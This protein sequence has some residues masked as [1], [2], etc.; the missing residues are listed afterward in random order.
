M[1]ALALSLS[2]RNVREDGGGALN[3][4]Q[5]EQRHRAASADEENKGE[6]TAPPPE[7]TSVLGQKTVPEHVKRRQTAAASPVGFRRWGLW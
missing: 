3:R 4:A 5:E 2:S 1:R 7:T 6:E